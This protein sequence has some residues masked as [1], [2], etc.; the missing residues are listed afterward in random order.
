[1]DNMEVIKRASFENRK[2]GETFSQYI[3]ERT[4]AGEMVRLKVIWAAGNK[5]PR[6]LAE[7]IT[8]NPKKRGGW[9][10]FTEL[11]PDVCGRKDPISGQFTGHHTWYDALM[12]RQEGFAFTMEG[13]VRR[14]GRQ[15]VVV[16]ERG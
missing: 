6:I 4:D 2:L 1:M 14:A 3:S 8:L 9:V 11:L 5:R 13:M 15:V 16:E 10:E 12:N 7:F